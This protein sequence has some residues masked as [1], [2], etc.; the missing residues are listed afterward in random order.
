MKNTSGELIFGPGDSTLRSGETYLGWNDRDSSRL[1][2]TCGFL[3]VLFGWSMMLSS[4]VH[5]VS[6]VVC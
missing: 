1:F 3:V 4:F 5:D 6:Y 2:C